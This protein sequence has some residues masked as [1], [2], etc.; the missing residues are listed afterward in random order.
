MI[1]Y[2]YGYDLINQPYLSEVIDENSHLICQSF[3]IPPGV[4]QI[5]GLRIKASKIGYPGPIHYSIGSTPGG[6][7]LAE[8]EI[9][10]E[11]VLPVFELLVG[12]EFSPATVFEGETYYISLRVAHGKKPLDAYRI[13]G[14]NIYDH[15]GGPESARLPYWWTEYVEATDDLEIPLPHDYRGAQFPDYAD[16]ARYQKDGTKAWSISFAILTDQDRRSEQNKEEQRFEFVRKLVAPPFS[17]WKALRDRRQKTAEQGVWVDD[18]WQVVC[19][20]PHTLVTRNAVEELETFF[21]KVMEV[22]LKAGIKGRQIA[23]AVD[24]GTAS[25]IA[26]IPAGEESFIVRVR[27][28]G[29]RIT[30]RTD[31][32]LLKAVHWMEDQMLARRAPELDPGTYQVRSKYSP[33]MVPGIYPA[34]SYS[35]LMDAQVWTPGYV[36]RLARAGYNAIFIQANM[37]D[38]VESS[39]IFPEMNDAQAGAAIERLRQITELGAAYGVAVYIDLKTGYSKKFSQAVYARLPEIR[40]YERFGNYPCSGQQI[41]LDFYKETLAHLFTQAEKLQGVIVIYDTEGFFSCFIHNLQHKCPY[42]KDYPVVE[43]ASRLF[44]AIKEGI[45]IRRPDRELILWSYF[46]DEPWNYELIRALPADVSLIACFSQFVELERFDTR[47]RTDDYSIC[48]EKPSA[49]FLTILSIAREKGLRFLCKTED[50]FGQEFVSTPYTPCLEQHQL[51]WDSVAQQEVDGFLSQYVH[52]GFMPGPCADL[53]RQNMY[54]VEKDGS[55]FTPT[56]EEKLRT[57]AALQYGSRAVEPVVKA[58]HAFTTAIRDYFPYT[59]GVC[60]YPGPLQSAPAQPFYLDP[61]RRVPRA[62]S[63]G[64]VKDLKWTGIDRRF[65]VD[66]GHPWNAAV[67][68]RCFSHFLRSYRQGNRFLEEAVRCAEETD[69]E[70]LQEALNVARTQALQVSSMLNF[71]QFIQLRDAYLQNQDR[72]LLDALIYACEM[73]MLNAGEALEICRRDSRIGFSCEGAGNV[74]GGLFTPL[75]IEQ[76][77]AALHE[78]LADLYQQQDSTA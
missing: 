7:E 29:I 46:C 39:A 40:S 64:Y 36:W 30:A 43:L 22:D 24:E 6:K 74:R 48:S 17:E 21:D 4:K 68:S 5:Y 55:L 54:M 25:G 3:K 61:E 62:R 57:V 53:M 69:Q 51:R 9:P 60:R 77:I 15:T 27:P 16:G 20:T 58:W 34:P 33:R 12:S 71:I 26:G 73:E 41:V 52:V 11:E 32:G 67:V 37:E 75:A 72:T 13:Y 47:I 50:T 8:G 59:W 78:T 44:T 76:K 14:P 42:C 31:R 1:R 18:Q 35:L 23:L 10:A 63:R 49:N 56:A 65:L 2:D 28:E 66:P 70:A 45:R 19:N 38:F